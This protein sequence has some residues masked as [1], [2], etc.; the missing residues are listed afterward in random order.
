MEVLDFVGGHTWFFVVIELG[1]LHSPL[2]SWRCVEG[3]EGGRCE[4]V[5]QG[6]CCWRVKGLLYF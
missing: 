5:L 1:P 6:N 2:H 3:G 4:F